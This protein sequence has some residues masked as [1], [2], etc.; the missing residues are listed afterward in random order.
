MAAT[1]R[2]FRNL[3]TCYRSNAPDGTGDFSANTHL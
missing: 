3:R 1:V 2:I